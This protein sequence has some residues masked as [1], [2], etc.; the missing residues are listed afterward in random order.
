VGAF[1]DD[2]QLGRDLTIEERLRFLEG[3]ALFLDLEPV[4]VFFFT[5]RVV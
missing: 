1:C 5:E 4:G 3:A 2:R